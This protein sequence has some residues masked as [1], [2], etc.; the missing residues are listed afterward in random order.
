[1]IDCDGDTVM[2]DH[3]LTSTDHNHSQN[4]Q[5]ARTF[6]GESLADWYPNPIFQPLRDARLASQL[7]SLNPASTADLK[8]DLRA[9]PGGSEFQHPERSLPQRPFGDMRHLPPPNSRSQPNN[10]NTASS[11]HTA[12]R[13][14]FDPLAGNPFPRLPY[15]DGTS[16][17]PPSHL[18]AQTFFS[19]RSSLEIHAHLPSADSFATLRNRD[20]PEL[21]ERRLLQLPAIGGQRPDSPHPSAIHHQFDDSFQESLAAYGSEHDSHYDSLSDS[22]TRLGRRAG[23][24]AVD[25][26]NNNDTTTRPRTPRPHPLLRRHRLMPVMPCSV[27]LEDFPRDSLLTLECQCH[28]CND[29]LNG[30]FRAGCANMASFPPRCCGTPLRILVWGYALD[31]DV[32]ERYKEVEAEFSSHRPLYCAK[33]TCSEFIPDTAYIEAEEA[34]RCPTCQTLTC[35]L[36]LKEE[37]THSQWQLGRRICPAPD[38]DVSALLNLGVRRNWRQCPTCLVMVE[39]TDGCNHVECVCGV[40]FCYVCGDLYDEEG[41]CDCEGAWGQNENDDDNNGDNNEEEED[42]PDFRAAVDNLGRPT[43]LHWDTDVLEL[44]AE[45]ACHGCL[46]F[47]DELKGCRDC[48]LELCDLCLSNIHGLAR[49]NGEIEQSSSD[50]VGQAGARNHATP[51]RPPAHQRQR[52]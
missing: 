12:L 20:S 45:E 21:V 15:F 7:V 2:E 33:K 29:C 8:H 22:L 30:A 6:F 46:R 14:M 18:H 10:Y 32:L 51:G 49:I 41:I 13:S 39:K 4:S 19:S 17:T 23:D 24:S 48:Q 50:E 11:S 44:D 9:I 42:W 27:C 47:T 52:A 36:C 16:S 38:A 28:Y 5:P 31:A 26:N 43:C 37:A 3:D 1:M 35:K 40:D 34:G 25:D